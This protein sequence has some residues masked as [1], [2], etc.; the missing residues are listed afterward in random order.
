[1]YP[2]PVVGYG[3]SGLFCM[4]AGTWV[5]FCA[6]V[7][8]V[9]AGGLCGGC[10]WNNWSCPGVRLF[11]PWLERRGWGDSSCS[12]VSVGWRGGARGTTG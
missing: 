9:A 11:G 5:S 3:R 12:H 8:L 2:H 1:M 4:G 6:V 10:W 7:G